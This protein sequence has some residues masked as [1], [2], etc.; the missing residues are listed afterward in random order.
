M[1]DSIPYELTYEIAKFLNPEDLK[2][3]R[4]LNK[5]L[6]YFAENIFAQKEFYYLC[7]KGK[8]IR[9]LKYL[10]SR[11]DINPSSDNNHCLTIKV[12]LILCL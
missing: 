3:V 12:L 2:S 6:V 9:R 5:S 8:D 11:G 4:L 7:Y 1:I 10:L